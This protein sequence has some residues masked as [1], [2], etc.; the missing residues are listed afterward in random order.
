M[1]S[2]VRYIDGLELRSVQDDGRYLDVV[3]TTYGN[4]VDVGPFEERM[5]KGVFDTSLS[6]HADS[7]KLVVGHDDFQPAV[8][9]PVEWSK[10]DKEL[11][12]TFKFGTHDEAKRAVQLAE[13][14]MF[15]G[16]SVA[17]L[18]GKKPGDSVWEKTA[19]GARV[20]RHQARLLH[21]G[22]VTVPANADSRLLAVRS[23][24]IPDEVATP[25][26]DDARRRLEALA[27]RWS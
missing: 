13:E 2:E 19:T 5:M 10:G 4:W 6:R 23:M 26:L 14:R 7:I 17:F 9:T 24:G 18:P 3:V 27:S 22:M 25:R 1:P 12:A 21:V 20:T 15:G 11:R 8:G 16:V